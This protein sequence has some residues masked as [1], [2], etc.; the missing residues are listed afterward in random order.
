MYILTYDECIVFSVRGTSSILDSFSTLSM[1]KKILQDVQYSNYVDN[2]IYKKIKVHAGFLSQYNTVKFN[3]IANVFEKMWNNKVSEK[4]P[5]KVIFTSHSLGAAISTLAAAT[6]KAQFTTNVTIENWTFGCPR[7]G[8]KMFV[9]YYN[10]KVDKTFR[11]VCGD[12]IVTKIP[13]IGFVAF[14]DIIHLIDE[15]GEPRTIASVE[16]GHPVKT[17]KEKSSKKSKSFAGFKK[18]LSKIFGNSNDHSMA[19]YIRR[20]N[21][22]NDNSITF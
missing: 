18:V 12:D 19:E 4:G 7:I 17:K 1:S 3:I 14:K 22:L 5:V 20:I 16:S 11:Y 6:L 8:N 13:K 10:D 9:K 15:N 21:K 2:K